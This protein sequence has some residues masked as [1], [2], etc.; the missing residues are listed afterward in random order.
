M[1]SGMEK[2]NVYFNEAQ[3]HLDISQLFTLV[4]GII[5][6]DKNRWRIFSHVLFCMSVFIKK[7][8]PEAT[9]AEGSE[10]CVNV[11]IAKTTGMFIV[12]L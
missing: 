12:Q 8:E 4:K 6:K 11:K 7:S 5:Q 1:Y 3:R 10:C 9:T 2:Q